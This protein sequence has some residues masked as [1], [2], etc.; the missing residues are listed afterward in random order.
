MSGGSRLLTIL[1]PKAGVAESQRGQEGQAYALRFRCPKS[2]RA[3]LG[4]ERGVA[5]VTRFLLRVGYGGWCLRR[6][7]HTL[8]RLVGDRV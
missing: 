6:D 5:G 3:L 2:G 8:P 1:F 4:A 7:M